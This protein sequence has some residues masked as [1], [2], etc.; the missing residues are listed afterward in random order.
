MRTKKMP[1]F[2]FAP[3]TYEIDEFDCVSVF[4]FVG[5]ERALL[6]DTGTGVGDIRGL[7]E[8]LTDKPVTELNSH[9]HPDHAMGA[10]EFETA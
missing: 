6:L 4:L 2:E 9:G 1:W 3:N 7:V 5:T 8:D 10:P